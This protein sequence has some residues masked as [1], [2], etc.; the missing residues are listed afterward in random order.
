LRLLA[1]GIIRAD[2]RLFHA[3][4]RD[5]LKP[6]RE[7][8]CRQARTINAVP[9]FPR[10]A[11]EPSR[12]YRRREVTATKS[13]VPMMPTSRDPIV[14]KA[15]KDGC[16]G[17]QTKEFLEVH[18]GSRPPFDYHIYRPAKRLR[19]WRS[20]IEIPKSIL[21]KSPFIWNGLSLYKSGG[22]PTSSPHNWCCS[23]IG[24]VGFNF[25]VFDGNV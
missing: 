1:F 25:R 19:C 22:L 11:N 17:D 6:P 24:P 8:E 2:A 7:I 15:A 21:K 20:E 23:I 5:G 14:R 13:P 10:S 16:V 9:S 4:K 3:V 12:N 18:C